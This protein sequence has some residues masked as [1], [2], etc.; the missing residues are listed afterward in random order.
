[1]DYI[2]DKTKLLFGDCLERMKEIPD[3]SI[4][5]VITDPPYGTT[6]LPWDSVINLT[7]LWKE[8][9]RITT[10]HAP[11][12]LFSA[13]PFTTVLCSS[14]LENLK[15]TLVWQKTKSANFNQ[16]PNMPLKKHEDICVFS[17]GVIGH[18]VQTNKRMT[19]N[20]QGIE[21]CDMFVQR[22]SLDNDPYNYQRENGIVKGYNQT[23]TNY[24]SS[25]LTYGSE[26]NPKHPTQKPLDLMDWL[27]NTYSNP[28]ETVLDFTMGSGSTI[29]SAIQNDRKSI[30]IELDKTYFNLAKSRVEPFEIVDVV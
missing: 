30:G 8:L 1:M 6:K 27:V 5:C 14:N 24:P 25:V 21:S 3:N 16:A 23:T 13:Q 12:V 11:I 29:V 15:Y 4:D 28:G 19:Y 10:I 17:K 26:H 7:D 18:K 2:T 20:P 22:P 9:N